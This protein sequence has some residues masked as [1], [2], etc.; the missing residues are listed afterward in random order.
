MDIQTIANFVSTVGFP[1]VACAAM[2]Y[3]VRE[4][5]KLHREEIESLRKALDANTAA[6]LRLETIM[7]MLDRRARD[8]G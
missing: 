6:L 3:M 8:E 7:N 5:D 2:F 1:I 4:N